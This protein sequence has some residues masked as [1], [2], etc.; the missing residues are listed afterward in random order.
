MDK[1]SLHIFNGA[2]VGLLY[3]EAEGDKL[4]LPDTWFCRAANNAARNLFD[5]V[6]PDGLT[7]RELFPESIAE[8]LS[9]ALLTNPATSEVDFFVSKPGAWLLASGNR[10]DGQLTVALTDITKQKQAAFADQRMLN[11]Y[12]S[13]FNSLPDKEIILFDKDFNVVLA[14]GA[15]RF[16]SLIHI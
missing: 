2:P 15:P 6:S 11:L 1:D 13:L 3:F 9:D 16:L 7:L 14:E 5:S 4:E 8:R 12:K 10:V